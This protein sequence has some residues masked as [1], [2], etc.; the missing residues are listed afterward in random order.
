MINRKQKLLAIIILSIT[1]I[2]PTELT[3]VSSASTGVIH[4]NNSTSTSILGETVQIGENINLYFGDTAIPSGLVTLYLSQNPNTQI[5]SSDYMFTP[6]ILGSYITSYG[7][8]V[9]NDT[10]YNSWITGYNWINGSIPRSTQPGIYY[11]K[12]VNYDTNQVLAV[13]DTS[14]TVAVLGQLQLSPATGTAESEVQFTGSGFTPNQPVT[15]SYYDPVRLTWN[16]WETRTANAVGGLTFV[17]QMP[18]LGSSLSMG[19]NGESTKTISFK[20]YGNGILAFADYYQYLRGLKIVGDQT[21]EGLFGNGTNLVYSVNAKVGDSITISGK[22]FHPNDAIYVR[23]DGQNE[24]VTVTAEEWRNAQIVGNSIA[25]SAGSFST[26][27]IVPLCSV[28]SHY[29]AVEDS[30]CKLIVQITVT[31]STTLNLSPFNGPGGKTVQLTGQNFPAGSTIDLMY[32]DSAFNTWKYLSSVTSN[33]AGQIFYSLVIP[34]IGRSVGA[35]DYSEDSAYNIQFRAQINGIVYSTVDYYQYQRGIKTIGSYTAQGLFGN[36]TDLIDSVRVEKGKQVTITGKW[37]HPNDVIYVR[38]DGTGIY[39]TVSGNEWRN[40]Q[41][42]GTSIADSSGYFSVQVTI[43]NADIGEH[44]IAIEDSNAKIIIKVLLSTGTI[45]INPISGPGGALVKITGEGYPAS[46]PVTLEYMNPQTGSWS[47]WMS[48]SSEPS[49]KI[50]FTF[51]IPDLKKSLGNGEYNYDSSNVINY[52]L[53]INGAIYG[54]VSYHQ[55]YRGLINVGTQTAYGLYGNGTNF[56]SNVQV[57]AGETLRI[58]GKYFH[59]GVVYIRWDGQSVVGTVTAN[60]WSQ[61]TIIGTT[62][63]NDAG[64]FDTTVNIPVA[65]EGSHYISIEDTQTRL[66]ISVQATQVN[67]PTPTPSQSPTPTQTPQSS[68]TPAPTQNPTPTVTPAP[69]QTATLE[70]S[71]PIPTINVKCKSTSTD[72]GFKV[73]INGLVTVSDSALSNKAVQ[74]YYSKDGGINWESLT[75]VTTG[76]DGRFN[77]V[78]ISAASGVFMLKAECAPNTEYNQATATISFAIEPSSETSENVFTMTSNSTISQLRFDS[79][80]SEF[81][82]AASG[83]T[84]THGYVTVNIPKTLINNIAN[85]KVFLDGNA[86]TFTSSEE[87]DSWTITIAYTHSTHTI[88]MAL[89]SNQTDK[90]PQGNQW[91]VIG[92]SSITIAIVAA[93][94]VAVINKKRHKR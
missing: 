69:T 9:V 22:Y 66:I 87:T 41:I 1:I 11:I 28:G 92:A 8:H 58:S 26:K 88:V 21:A 75:Q 19:D 59:P 54:T 17:K 7:Y 64:N 14:F 16:T 31:N 94:I 71:K 40:A 85:L 78:W 91:I 70:P 10:S 35:G 67:Q 50:C 38:W 74:L 81:R 60:Q 23:W 62:I 90:Q 33:Q 30:Q 80:T 18:D 79:E 15:I 53:V 6:I 36:G 29:V 20:A 45:N 43:P 89:N 63:A 46:S 24:G 37:F 56:A 55:Y 12:L 82:F 86:V 61:A 34:D 13:T 4:I 93:S 3:L 68:T 32:L 42:I 84:N 65:S 52:R 48:N 83:K 44:Y 49:G 47:Y 5:T 77:A 51:E 57:K 25:N 72:N 27:F 2:I 39:G 76:S 73:E